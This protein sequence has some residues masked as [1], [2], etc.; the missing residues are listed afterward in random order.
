MG[1]AGE[2]GPKLRKNLNTEAD[3]GVGSAESCAEIGDFVRIMGKFLKREN[4]YPGRVAKDSFGKSSV[5]GFLG[6]GCLRGQVYSKTRM[7]P[8]SSGT[9]GVFH[10][11]V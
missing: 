2:K 10:V 9:S 5:S 3:Q 4:S 11:E 7:R 8:S 6:C 1:V